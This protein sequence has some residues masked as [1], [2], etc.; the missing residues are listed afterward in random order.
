MN[1]HE[2]VGTSYANAESSMIE[3]LTLAQLKKVVHN[4]KLQFNENHRY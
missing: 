4:Y 3:S 2:D 1:N